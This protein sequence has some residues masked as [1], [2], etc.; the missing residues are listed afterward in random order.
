MSRPDQNPEL[1]AAVLK[2]VAFYDTVA[3]LMPLGIVP[4]CYDAAH[5]PT[6][7]AFTSCSRTSRRRTSWSPSG[8]CLPNLRVLLSRRNCTPALRAQLPKG[9]GTNFRG[10]VIRGRPE[11]AEG[12]VLPV[13]RVVVLHAEAEGQ[14]QADLQGERRIRRRRYRSGPGRCPCRCPSCRPRGG[15]PLRL[16]VE[17]DARIQGE[18]TEPCGVAQPDADGDIRIRRIA[19]VRAHGIC[20]RHWSGGPP[21]TWRSRARVVELGTRSSARGRVQLPCAHGSRCSDDPGRRAP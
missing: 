11:I 3:P 1:A 14:G 21:A 15:P 10:S 6:A 13:D 7:S 20:M 5:D 16:E 18:R 19:A 4:R 8:R 9:A 17:H 2:E 12:L